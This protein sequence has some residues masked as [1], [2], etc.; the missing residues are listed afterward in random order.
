MLEVPGWFQAKVLGKAEGWFRKPEFWLFAY[1]WAH[2]IPIEGSARTTG[3]SHATARPHTKVVARRVEL[4][5][6]RVGEILKTTSAP[7]K[8]RTY[9]PNFQ[10]AL[11]P[12]I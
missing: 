2:A 10:T 9:A 11:S 4:D 6:N 12:G 3:T 8:E 5:M 7:R 1:G